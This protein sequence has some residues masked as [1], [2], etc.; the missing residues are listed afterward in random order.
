M[1]KDTWLNGGDGNTK[2][3]HASVNADRSSKFMAELIDGNG[4]KQRA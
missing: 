1:S 2:Y 3:F 4:H